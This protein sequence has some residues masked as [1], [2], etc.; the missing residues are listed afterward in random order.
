MNRT[1]TQT[2]KAL[3][4]VKK[5]GGRLEQRL[6]GLRKLHLASDGP[7]AIAIIKNEEARDFLMST[8]RA[9]CALQETNPGRHRRILNKHNTRAIKEFCKMPRKFR[10]ETA[11]QVFMVTGDM[12]HLQKTLGIKSADTAARLVTRVIASRKDDRG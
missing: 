5:R 6:E 1:P 10:E 7:G 11:V 8:M 12:K 2:I 9:F 4:R 3:L